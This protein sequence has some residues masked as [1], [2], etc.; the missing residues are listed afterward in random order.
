VTSRARVQFAEADRLARQMARHFGH[1][2]AVTEADGRWRVEIPAGSVELEP[3]GGLLLA[4]AEAADAAG[5]ARVEEVCA[6]HLV[7][8]AHEPLAIEW[9]PVD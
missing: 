6:D 7:R 5:L 3:A 4:Q 8:F 9:A 2:V 1:K